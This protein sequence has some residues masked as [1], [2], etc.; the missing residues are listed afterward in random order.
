M[1]RWLL[2]LGKRASSLAA[3][4][5]LLLAL[6]PQV[7]AIGPSLGPD[8]GV[9]LPSTPDDRPPVVVV[10]LAAYR[11]H[12]PPCGHAAAIVVVVLRDPAALSGEWIILSQGPT[13]SAVVNLYAYCG[14]DPINRIDP[15]GLAFYAFDGTNNNSELPEDNGGTN[16]AVMYELVNKTASYNKHYYP[17]VGNRL[18]FGPIDGFGDPTKMSEWIGAGAGSGAESIINKAMKDFVRD[19]ENGDKDVDITGFSRGSAM[20]LEFANRVEDYVTNNSIQGVNLRFVGLYDTVSS[21]NGRAENDAGYRVSLPIGRLAVSHRN[22]FHWFAV[23]EQRREFQVRDI[24]GATQ[25]GFRGAHSDVGG[26]YR[27]K[28]LSNIALLEM[29]DAARSVG[30]PILTVT[31]AM[32]RSPAARERFAPYSS[33]DPSMRPHREINW[34]WTVGPRRMPKGGMIPAGMKPPPL[35]AELISRM[36]GMPSGD[37]Y[38]YSVPIYSYADEN[39]IQE[40]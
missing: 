38:R 21:F 16:V 26:G 33:T 6:V 7:H 13:H 19:L 18:D 1:I 39:Y 37:I 10:Y 5:L 30:V 22:A 14:G 24:Q 9:T 25:L 23:D 31:E 29:V 40:P 32:A 3:V 36:L 27:H 11:A 2:H 35:R 34:K 20:A 12:G 4:F 17:G 8:Q 28:G 15:S